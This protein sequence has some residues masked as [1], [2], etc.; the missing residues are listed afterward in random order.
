[1]KCKCEH[2]VLIFNPN[3]V[4]LWSICHKHTHSFYNMPWTTLYEMK[5]T[6]TPE[7]V[8]TFQMHDEDGV[9]YPIF[10]YVPC[11]HCRLCREKKVSD[12]MTRCMCESAASEYPPLFITL[13]YDPLHLPLDG[14]NKKDVQDFMKRLRINVSRH[15]KE[16]VRLRF[17]L[18]AEYGKIKKRAH[19]HM[20]LWNMPFVRPELCLQNSFQALVGFIQDAWSHGFVKVERSRDLTGR[21]CM[22]Y[23][24]KESD[25]PEGCNPTFYL[26]S[27]RR[28]IGYQWCADHSNEVKDNWSYLMIRD[29]FSGK[30]NTRPIPDYF[31][32]IWYPTLSQLFPNYVTQA[33]KTFMYNSCVFL[34][35]C[36]LNWPFENHIPEL[37]KMVEYVSS[38]YDLMHI[39][40]DDARPS[41]HDLRLIYRYHILT[42]HK[43]HLE[44]CRLKEMVP[45]NQFLTDS[46]LYNIRSWL[47]TLFI[48][49]KRSYAILEKYNF[50]Y[51]LF[52]KKLDFTQAHK[53]WQLTYLPDDDPDIDALVH[54]YEVDRRWEN[55]HWLEDQV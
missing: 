33:C 42:S 45:K 6:V 50:D 5:K 34:Q 40:F 35:F 26:A 36:N 43:Y 38:K 10:M 51:D 24:R 30:V 16:D 18:V 15:L 11:G 48:D 49:L 7:N 2:P 13:T 29:Q 47:I 28:G 23:M 37:I 19:Y 31:K 39:D 3:L 55:T 27:R 46:T 1:M 4:Y 25:V 53:D 12:W 21:Y 22:K 32:R 41:T 44:T 54:K 17:F 20:L 14:V 8:D 52:K 9:C